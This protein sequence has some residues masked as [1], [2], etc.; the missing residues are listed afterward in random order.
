MRPRGDGAGPRH[1]AGQSIND[2][3]HHR[4]RRGR[5][6][7]A[8]PRAA[9][10]LRQPRRQLSPDAAPACRW[11]APCGRILM[12]D[13]RSRR[14]GRAALLLLVS[15]AG[16][17]AQKMATMNVTPPPL[18][19][20][21]EEFIFHPDPYKSEDIPRRL[22]RAEVAKFLRERIEAT[23]PFKSLRQAEKVVE[24]YDLQEI[25]GHFESLLKQEKTA[26]AVLREIVLDRS[27]AIVCGPREPAYARQ[28]YADLIGRA[29]T[30]AEFQE[31][32]W[33]NDAVSD[34]EGGARLQARI[35]ALRATVRTDD[36][37]AKLESHKPE[38]L[39]NV[40]LSRP[41]IA[42]AVQERNI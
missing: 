30:T 6:D 42:N 15:L 1:R 10:D 38:E 31:L 32:V 35:A 16:L 3:R 21:L 23:T 40:R 28:K 26:D 18:P 37:Q 17:G 14:R 19:V 29:T 25:C 12:H 36:Y 27:L 20:Q 2:Q 8:H 5:G 24:F 9:A 22:P 4:G 39:E 41:E 33:L 34:P 7:Q 11:R 13:K